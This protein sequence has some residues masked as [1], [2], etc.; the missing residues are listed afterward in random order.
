[1]LLERRL[2]RGDMNASRRW[3]GPAVGFQCRTTR[4]YP[5]LDPAVS[6][7]MTPS[8]VG[9]GSIAATEKA[10]SNRLGLE[11]AEGAA[12]A[13]WLLVHAHI[14]VSEPATDE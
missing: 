9:R 8:K 2:H 6:T 14:T 11:N 1:M 13:T 7:V 5:F 4:S 12:D 10:S 3:L